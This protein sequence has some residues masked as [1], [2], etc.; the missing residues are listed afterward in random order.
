MITE[1][2][3]TTEI[4]SRLFNECGDMIPPFVN[5]SWRGCALDRNAYDNIRIPKLLFETIVSVTRSENIQIYG[6]YSSGEICTQLYASW[7]AYLTFMQ[8]KENWSVEYVIT[9]SKN[10]WAIL[11][12][13]DTTIIG[14]EPELADIVDAILML[15]QTSLV[16]ITD[17]EFPMLN[18]ETQPGARYILAVSGR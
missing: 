5:H 14:M 4:R 9:D 11:A 15:Q 8:A 17:S 12:E 6:Y 1:S 7:E 16:Q 18:P 2:I 3:S 13:A 10:Q